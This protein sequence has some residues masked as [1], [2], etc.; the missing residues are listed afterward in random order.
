MFLINGDNVRL[1]FYF[2]YFSLGKVNVFL[3]NIYDD[4]LIFL[5]VDCFLN[6]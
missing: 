5:G 3:K 4:D 6:T 1:F 2:Y